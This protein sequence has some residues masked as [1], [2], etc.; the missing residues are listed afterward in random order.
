M[1][2]VIAT[3]SIV[4]AALVIVVSIINYPVRVT[5]S[6]WP[7]LPQYTFTDVSVS[8]VIFASAFAGSLFMGIIAI[9]EGSKIRLSN[10]RLRAQIRRLQQESAALKRRPEDIPEKELEVSEPPL[11]DAGM[12]D[13]GSVSV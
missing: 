10:A 4:F 3:L 9:L 2:I 13:S 12:E 8:W 7:D 1:R 6:L 11:E 5:V